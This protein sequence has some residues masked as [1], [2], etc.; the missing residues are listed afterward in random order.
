MGSAYHDRPLWTRGPHHG[1]DPLSLQRLVN[2]GK[3]RPLP[4][5]NGLQMRGGGAPPVSHPHLSSSRGLFSIRSRQS[6]TPRVQPGS[7]GPEA[8]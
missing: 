5:L 8:S 1:P 4:E 2:L 7:Q 3:C 6:R